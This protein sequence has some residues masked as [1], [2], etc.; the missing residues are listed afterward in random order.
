[1]NIASKLKKVAIK[2]QVQNLEAAQKTA[3]EKVIAVCHQYA[4]AGELQCVLKLSATQ[5]F[6]VPTETP[7]GAEEVVAIP[8][9]KE[10]TKQLKNQGFNC[11]TTDIQGNQTLIVDWSGI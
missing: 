7:E 10:M 3:L 2:A 6:V 5:T 11:A 9:L 1:M 4:K 8:S